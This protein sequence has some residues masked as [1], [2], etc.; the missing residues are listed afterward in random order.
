MT[1]YSIFLS[2]IVSMGKTFLKEGNVVDLERKVFLE[3]LFFTYVSH[4]D[5][6]NSFYKS[7]HVNNNNFS[8]I[9][10]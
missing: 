6:I 9:K 2:G 1:A 4:S 3:A 5:Y 8:G 10:I 7:P